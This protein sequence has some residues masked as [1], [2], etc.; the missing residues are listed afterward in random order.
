MNNIFAVNTNTYHGFS[1][2]EA[3]EGISKA[4]F[5]YVELAGVKGWTEHVSWEMT[6]GQLDE[7]KA[8]LKKYGLKAIALGGHSNIMTDEGLENFMKNIKLAQRLQCEYIVTATG[9]TH[10][11]KEII[12][13]ED[14]LI[15]RLEKIVDKCKKAG[16]KVV[17]ETHGANYATG[18]K[19]YD[20]V[21]KLS[22]DFIGIN[23]DTA[24]VIFYGNVKPEEDIKTCVD[25]IYFIHLKDK[26]GENQEW[27]FPAV[28]KGLI[29]FEDIFKTL[30]ERD[31]SY[32]I[33]LE[34]EFTPDGPRSVDEVHQGVK[35]SYNYIQ[36]LIK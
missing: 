26:L 33:S 3:L 21:N 30:K 28:G 9:E 22:S 5:K 6:D 16:I 32:P 25:K 23:Y 27:N 24:N 10:G 29:D 31:Y 2:D 36:K 11:D 4:G 35:D 34:I 20:L 1:L 12:E 8:K 17:L 7:V 14:I 15:E 19:L 18:K 13:D